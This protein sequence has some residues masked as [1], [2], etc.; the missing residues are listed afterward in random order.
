MGQEELDFAH[1]GHT[2]A[3]KYLNTYTYS[4]LK[5]I[6]KRSRSPAAHNRML[7]VAGLPACLSVCCLSACLSVSIEFNICTIDI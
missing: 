4:S 5:E 7:S 2:R 3:R 6:I 1:S